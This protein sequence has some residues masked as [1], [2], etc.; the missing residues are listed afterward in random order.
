MKIQL[1]IIVFLILTIS[2]K[3]PNR[4]SD[5]TNNS[6]KKEKVTRGNLKQTRGRKQSPNNDVTNIEEDNTSENK[7]ISDLFLELQSEVFLV[8]SIDNFEKISQGSGFFVGPAIGVTNNHVLENS[9]NAVI[10]INNEVYE[11]SEILDRSESVD[12]D[13][14][15]F[16]TNYITSSPLKIANNKARIGD[17]IFAIGSPQGLTNSLTKGTISGFRDNHRIQIDATIDHGSSGGPLFNQKGE[18]IGITTSGLGTGSELNFAVDI[19]VLNLDRF[20][21]N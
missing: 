6:L 7:S 19:Q 1:S 20:I 5:R 16:K 4:S 2:C 13:Y 10:S 21:G 12:K 9:K 15:I 18:V 3:R 14:I 8:Y 17:D 11:I